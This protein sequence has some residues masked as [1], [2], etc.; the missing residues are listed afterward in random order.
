[1]AAE[2]ANEVKVLVE[3]ALVEQ[4]IGVATNRQSPAGFEDMVVVQ[5][6]AIGVLRQG[7]AIDHGLAVVLASLL[8]AVDF[9]QPIGG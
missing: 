9:E 8:Q 3:A 5:G 2:V 1:M 6:E 7:A 4:A